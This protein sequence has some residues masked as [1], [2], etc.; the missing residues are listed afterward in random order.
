MNK[1]IRCLDCNA[2]HAITPLD[3]APEYSPAGKAAECQT[4]CG[5]DFDAIEKDDYAA[6]IHNH[7]GH[8]TEQLSIIENSSYSEGP[9]FD[10]H[11]V[12]F[13]ETTNGT[14]KFLIKR[15]RRSVAD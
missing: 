10:P 6:F 11:R 7:A 1:L 14:D 9:Y 4:E 2:I 15:W 3:K 5:L 8:S 12:L 13:F